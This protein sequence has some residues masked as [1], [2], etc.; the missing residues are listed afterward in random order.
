VTLRRIR[1]SCVAV[2]PFAAPPL[3]AADVEARD[4][5]RYPGRECAGG[6]WPSDSPSTSGTFPLVSDTA[7]AGGIRGPRL[8]VCKSPAQRAF[9]GAGGNRTPVHQALTVR[10]TTVPDIFP[11]A[12]RPAG[13]LGRRLPGGPRTVFPARHSSFRTSADLCRRHPSLLLPGC[14]GLA[15]CVIADHDDSASPED[16]AVRAKLLFSTVMFFA[17]FS[18]SEQLGSHA[19]PAT[20]T[21]KPVS[22]VGKREDHA[23][24]ARSTCRAVRQSWISRPRSHQSHR[25]HTASVQLPGVGWRP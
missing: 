9:C 4:L 22:P 3:A 13:Q 14:D 20:L 15:P 17:P 21:S 1:E 6:W 23:T 2:R 25:H 11:D 10:A 5:G 18:E 7:V 16:Q 8:G 19:R 24:S 12:G